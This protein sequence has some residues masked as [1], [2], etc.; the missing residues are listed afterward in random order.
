MRTLTVLVSATLLA[1]AFAGCIGGE[2]P[3]DD[4]T[5]IS[6]ESTPTQ[7]APPPAGAL[8]TRTPLDVSLQASQA[9]TRPGESVTF[10]ATSTSATEYGW[11]LSPRPAAAPSESGGGG[12]HLNV[13]VGTDSRACALGPGCSGEGGQ[14]AKPA[15]SPPPAA[16]TGQLQPGTY[17]DPIT[18]GGTGLYQ[19]HCH[20]HPWMALNI[21]VKDDASAKGTHH[22]EIV[23]GDKQDE[24]RFVPNELVLAPGAKVVF[25]NNG[26][27]MH[28]G[29]QGGFAWIIPVTGA[30]IE[31]APDFSGDFDVLVIAKDDANGY[32][33]ARTRLF[34][35]PQKPDDVQPVGPFKGEF[36]K[37]VP[38]EPE[39]ETKEH[40]F[41]SPFNI[42]SLALSFTAKSDVPVPP[43]MLV[44]LLQ[45]GK[46]IASA[47]PADSGEI[48]AENLP[49]GTYTVRVTAAQGVLITYEVTG[50]ATLELVAPEAT[51]NSGGGHH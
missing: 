35:D 1:G 14:E 25:W 43:T 26:T 18:F 13:P 50:T 29:T 7:G 42:T 20:P 36:Q 24:Y 47:G 12:H 44:S 40:P 8:A 41:T 33:E 22:V 5:S 4:L 39:P 31:Y 28:T 11:F 10:T 51:A 16:D 2:D 27:T 34:V 45:N 38:N 37:G 48:T 19:F 15:K 46:E 21:L 23:D 32:G 9:W 6:L 17:S 49:A 30:N 3:E